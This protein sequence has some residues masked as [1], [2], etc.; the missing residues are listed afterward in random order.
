[1]RPVIASLLAV[2]AVS[3]A[4]C[5]RQ[6]PATEQAN[7]ALTAEAKM[8]PVAGNGAAVEGGQV[9]RSHVGEAAPELA[10]VAPDGSQTSLESFRGKPV[11]L[12]LWATWCAPCVAELP[13]L[14]ALAER[15]ADQL[16]VIALSQDFDGKEKVE[17]FFADKGFANLQPYRDDEAA[18]SLSMQTNLPTTILYD[19]QGREVWRVLGDMDWTGEAAAELLAEVE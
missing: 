4:G 12:N 3:V 1:M 18:F 6:S 2:L 15:E 5:D 10:F 13:T 9:D 8:P 16:R 17:T 11:L 14:D 7:E 19:A